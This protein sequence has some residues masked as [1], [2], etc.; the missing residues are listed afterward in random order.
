MAPLHNP[1]ALAAIAALAGSH[2]GLPQVACFD[3]AFHA[4]IPRRA[5]TYALPREWR[6]AWGLRRYGF[7]GLSHAWA[8][9][10]AAEL[11]GR[12]ASELRLV[13]AHLGAGASLAAVERGVSVDTT[14]GFTPLEGLVMARRSGSVDPG[15]LLWVLR[16]GG[17]SA[18]EMDDALEHRS[19]LVGLAGTDDLRR[20]M[21]R[22]DA[23]DEAAALAHE[24]F[25]YRIRTN[26]GAMAAAMGGID[27]L[28]FTGGAGE[29]S[30]RLRADVASGLGFLGLSLDPD[31]NGATGDRLVSPDGARGSVAVVAAREDIEIARQVRRLL[32]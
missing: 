24:V 3:T 6:E 16:H 20:V 12:P 28:V 31:R 29:A 18:D 9:G 10:R 30:A 32:A 19:G 5:S 13:S 15:L 8:A 7:H 27:G 25:V 17:V 23:G 2:P 26:V 22:A 11:L 1:P 21:A 14:M 4:T